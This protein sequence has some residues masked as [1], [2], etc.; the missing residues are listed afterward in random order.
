MPND[1]AKV[2]SK[3]QKFLIHPMPLELSES[4]EVRAGVD[5]RSYETL[6][7]S[8]TILGMGNSDVFSVCVNRQS[9]VT[10]LH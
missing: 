5:L 3:Q 4:G 10:D 7:V 1:V 6:D 2:C 9:L 8:S